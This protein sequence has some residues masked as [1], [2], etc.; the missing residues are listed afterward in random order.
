MAVL[1]SEAIK[2]V[3]AEPDPI[4]RVRLAGEVILRLQQTELEIARLRRQAIELAA[5][6]GL[7]YSE[8]A[9]QVGLTRGRVSQ[10]RSDAPP[11][12]RQ[13]F[14]IGPVQ[15]GV[16]LRRM[17]ERELP[18]VASEDL[19]ARESLSELL[20]TLAFHVE[21]VEIDPVEDWEP[22]GSDLT[23]ICGPK[24]SPTIGKLLDADPALAFEPDENGRWHLTD[25]KTGHRYSSAMDDAN[26]SD[27]D[28]A[29]LGRIKFDNER[30]LVLIA[31]VHAIG[32][33][34]AVHYLRTNLAE[35]HREVG[36]RNYSMVVTST[37]DGQEIL[38]SE[39]ACPPRI[40]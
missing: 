6:G 7:S 17:P 3:L 24:S 12:E 22:A 8:V 31:G 4:R 36:T 13:F 35:L 1:D 11:E 33:L 5:A 27:S 23:A 14:G 40:H 34:G 20:S 19:V 26:P 38:T 16:P 25:R 10:I 37:H 29:Y 39:A 21:H 28:V 18:V 15:L 9:R 2:H 30:S 32:S